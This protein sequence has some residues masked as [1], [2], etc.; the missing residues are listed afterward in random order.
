MKV[1]CVVATRRDGMS[2]FTTVVVECTP[3]G[4]INGDHHAAAR[5][6]AKNAGCNAPYVVFDENDGPAWLFE[7][8]D[9]GVAG[10]VDIS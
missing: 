4:Y 8:F 10:Q 7:R 3:D 2:T 1:K 5:D 9:W 6:M